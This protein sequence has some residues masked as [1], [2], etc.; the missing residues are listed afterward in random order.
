MVKFKKILMHLEK[1]IAAFALMLG[2]ASTSQACVWWFHQPRVPKQ[3]K[4]IRKDKNKY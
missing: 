2:M 4:K 1:A 3:M